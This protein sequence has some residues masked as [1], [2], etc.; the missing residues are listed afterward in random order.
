MDDKLPSEKKRSFP[1]VSN[2]S[3]LKQHKTVEQSSSPSEAPFFFSTQSKPLSESPFQYESQYIS[4]FELKNQQQQ[5]YLHDKKKSNMMDYRHNR[6]TGNLSPGRLHTHSLNN[7]KPLPHSPSTY[8]KEEY[9]NVENVSEMK[10]YVISSLN[11]YK[12]TFRRNSD[13]HKNKY[14]KFNNFKSAH[15]QIAGYSPSKNYNSS[16]NYNRYNH[17]MNNRKQFHSNKRG[18][19]YFSFHQTDSIMLIQEALEDPWKHLYENYPK[20]KFT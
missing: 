6:K 20:M 3:D 2:T 1:E 10:N 16:N 13:E 15:S 11:V 17:Y 8:S 5:N 7:I 12:N 14:P 9:R 4:K 18:G 19:R